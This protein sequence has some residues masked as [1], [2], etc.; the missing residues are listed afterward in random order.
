MVAEFERDLIRQRT[1][2]GMVI[3]RAKG[4]LR[5]RAPKL[6]A[7]QE[8]HLVKLHAAGEHTASEL[9]ELF[10]IGRTTVYRVLETCE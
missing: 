6:S 4:R 8:A 7:N 2:E 10:G 5:G 1:C 3:A 9:A